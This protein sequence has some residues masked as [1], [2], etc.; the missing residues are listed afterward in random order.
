MPLQQPMTLESTLPCKV[1]NCLATFV[2]LAQGIL[3]LRDRPRHA[4]IVPERTYSSTEA[5]ALVGLTRKEVVALLARRDMHG[6]MINGNYRI[7]GRS[8]MNYLNG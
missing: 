2:A 8:I 1:L 5:A 6:K 4:D 7:L 3:L